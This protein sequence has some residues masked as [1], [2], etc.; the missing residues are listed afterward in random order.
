MHWRTRK[1]P[2]P[3]QE[4][5]EFGVRKEPEEVEALFCVSEKFLQKQLDSDISQII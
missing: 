4:T 5:S 1:L 2:S 3:L